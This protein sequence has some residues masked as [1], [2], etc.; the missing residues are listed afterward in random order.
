MKAKIDTEIRNILEN[1]L[2]FRVIDT[3]HIYDSDDYIYMLSEHLT[4]HIT[5]LNNTYYLLLWLVDIN[6]IEEEHIKLCDC[7]LDNIN[8][9][10]EQVI[11]NALI[12]NKMLII[13]AIANCRALV[14]ELLLVECVLSKY[15]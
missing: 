9:E 2:N 3:D 5:Y 12:T 10:L 13:D 14:D 11:V 15:N 1:K 6:D 4:L 8:K 7:I